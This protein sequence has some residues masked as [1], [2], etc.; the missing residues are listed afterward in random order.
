MLKLDGII[1]VMTWDEGR[2]RE[3]AG[4][5]GLWIEREGD[6]TL[7]LRYTSHKTQLCGEVDPDGTGFCPE[8]VGAQQHVQRRPRRGAWRGWKGATASPAPS[9]TSCAPTPGRTLAKDA[10][11]DG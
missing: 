10:A 7:N 5:T 9:S 1:P 4:E 2:E 3:R 8:P 6:G 11:G